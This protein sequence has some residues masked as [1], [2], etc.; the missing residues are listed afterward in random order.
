M[1]NQNNSTSPVSAISPQA[2]LPPMPPAFQNTSGGS[3]SG[4][5]V[6]A[7]TTSSVLTPSNSPVISSGTPRKKY[8]GGRII[9]TLL[10]ILVLVG[11]IGAGLVL[12][13]QQQLF[14]QQA[15]KKKKQCAD[16]SSGAQRA[17]CDAAYGLFRAGDQNYGALT[18]QQAQVAANSGITA[19]TVV[20][21]S[22]PTNVAPDNLVTTAATQATVGIPVNCT[23]T[24]CT[25]IPG[26]YKMPDGSTVT[27]GTL[28][29]YD[30]NTQLPYVSGGYSLNQVLNSA[31]TAGSNQAGA[32][33][34]SGSCTQEPD[35]NVA[36]YYP[37]TVN[38]Q[39]RY[40]PVQ[41]WTNPGNNNGGTSTTTT[42]STA[43]CGSVTAYD[44]S[45]GA[46][47]PAQLVALASGTSINICVGGTATSGSFDKAKFTVNGTAGA[48]VTAKGSGAAA[49]LF[50]EPY[51]IV[52][53]T[54]NITA[55]IHHTD[56]GWSY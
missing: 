31:T 56:L 12:T 33:C 54:N 37:Q 8:G 9:A 22:V 24:Q 38:G 51:T 6:E 50:C 41:T 15:A 5:P 23:G 21:P 3:T 43:S 48:E 42:T 28:S 46:L 30:P 35:T 55:Q 39:V 26:T 7:T 2:D 14:Q 4:A 36:G 47:T 32:Y 1:P 13:Q 29:S 44:S 34:P 16:Y 10:G 18:T 53:G 40:Y 45:W 17:S 11:G 27:V 20:T 19:Y 52:S 49:S 25:Q